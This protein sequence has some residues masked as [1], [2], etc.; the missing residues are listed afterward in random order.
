MMHS[1]LDSTLHNISF[2]VK[3]IPLAGLLIWSRE[4]ELVVEYKFQQVLGQEFCFRGATKQNLFDLLTIRKKWLT[5]YFTV[6]P[7]L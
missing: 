6:T 1:T 4:A 3:H 2:L 5:I 7:G